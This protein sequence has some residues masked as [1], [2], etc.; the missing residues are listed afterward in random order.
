MKFFLDPA[1]WEKARDTL[2]DVFKPAAARDP[3][4]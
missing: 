3:R 2:G 4:R 1:N